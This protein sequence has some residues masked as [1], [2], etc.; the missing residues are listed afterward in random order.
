MLDLWKQ[1]ALFWT[2]IWIRLGPLTFKSLY[3]P[4]NEAHSGHKTAQTLNAGF[5][6]TYPIDYEPVS[7]R[8]F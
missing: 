7:G 6:P 4:N 5:S 3:D 8:V 2:E 1:A